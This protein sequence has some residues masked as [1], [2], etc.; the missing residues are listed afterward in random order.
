M[1]FQFTLQ[2]LGWIIILENHVIT[3]R[4]PSLLL[5]P[6][7]KFWQKSNDWYEKEF[8]WKL[9]VILTKKFGFSQ[10]V[11]ADVGYL[12][13]TFPSSCK[14]S[15]SFARSWQELASL[16]VYLSQTLELF[17]GSSHRESKSLKCVNRYLV[18]VC[19]LTQMKFK[20]LLSLS[21]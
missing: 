3:C 11:F 2:F 8:I 18:T 4:K 15:T 13:Q 9:P 10:H 1:Q 21:L 14:S 7:N 12:Q 17:V 19:L 16:F 20:C 5:I 6:S